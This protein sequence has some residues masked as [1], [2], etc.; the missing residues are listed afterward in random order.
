MITG[1]IKSTKL[2]D[3]HKINGRYHLSKGVLYSELIQKY[4]SKKL[5]DF[6]TGIS[7][8]GVNQRIYTDKNHGVPLITI[9]ELNSIDPLNRCKYISK[10]YCYKRHLSIEPGMILLGAIGSVGEI[11]IARNNLSGGMTP[12]GNII[13]LM[14]NSP[15]E[16]SFLCAFFKNRYGQ[17]ILSRYQSGSVQKYLD[18]STILE[19]DV[20]SFPQKLLLKIHK[21]KEEASSQLSE[22]NRLFNESISEYEKLFSLR[23][24]LVKSKSL[25][26]A[27][28]SKT[29]RDRLDASFY[30]NIY[31]DFENYS[32]FLENKKF[33]SLN[34]ISNIFMPNRFKRVLVKE[35][36]GV[37]LRGIRGI[38]LLLNKD[39]KF[40]S[41]KNISQGMLINEGDILTA[42]SG[43]IGI[44]GICTA[45]SDG[46][47][48][49][50]DVIRIRS[51]EKYRNIILLY[52]SSEIG[53]EIL[54]RQAFGSVVIH[55]SPEQIEKIKL[56]YDNR[57]V[58]LSQKVG[59]ALKKRD[60][61]FTK[62]LSAIKI[63]EQELSKWLD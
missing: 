63:I 9:S 48:F 22:S 39:D 4:G 55:I 5:K 44:T 15:E 12:I 43:T 14:P 38:N 24:F 23:K 59:L 56:P 29:I 21:I 34:D 13:K 16:G 61:S 47:V 50:E 1:R 58:E 53:R 6:I 54:K 20:P 51:S 17:E 18:P 42:R 41:K 2:F 27:V 7:N 57:C 8:I 26:K 28:S 49:S 33:S 3:S 32:N 60:I 19:C 35:N 11:A 45:I 10:K 30:H 37:P 36:E 25:G 46:V 31:I 40:I 62:E 52:L